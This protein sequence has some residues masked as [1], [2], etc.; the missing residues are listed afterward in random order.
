MSDES[1]RRRVLLCAT[2]TG[3]QTRMFDEAADRLGVDL[4]LASDRCDRLEDPW[5]DRAIP[6]RF[7]DDAGAHAA[8]DA[9]LG[10]APLHGVLAVGDRP[11]VLAARV[12]EARGLPWHTVDGARAGRDKWRFRAAQRAA[13][14]TAPQGFVVEAGA[15]TPEGVRYPCV[16]KPLVLSGSRGVI[17][18]DTPAALTAALARVA[19]ILEAGDVL[20][21]RDPAARQILIE[22]YVEGHEFA[23]EGLMTH[24]AF[25]ALAVFDKPEPL[26]GPFFEETIYVTPTARTR[27]DGAA[28]VAAVTAAARASG[29]YH[30][31]VHA[32]CRM[33]ASGVVVLEAAARPIG[34]LCARALRLRDARG[35]EWPL[36]QDL[37]AHAI[38]RGREVTLAPGATGVMM[39]PIPRAGVLRAVD[40]VEAAR[41]VAGVTEVTVTANAGQILQTLPESASY[42]G[43]I[44]AQG[45]DDADVLAALAGAHACLHFTI[46]TVRPLRRE[47]A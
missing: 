39:V 27:T 43:F 36:E 26:A 41:A 31:P 4:V 2:T 3:Y 37:L 8:V 19:A 38:G 30:G 33:S 40:G 6:V 25:R 13:G 12:A 11:A 7:H 28:V 47:D 34:G 9:A 23:V 5:R 45:G 17:R 16:A 32:E 15:T 10:P 18:A 46:G 44:F 14:L 24:G 29:L 22:D 1:A 21:L 20:D 42:L 35:E